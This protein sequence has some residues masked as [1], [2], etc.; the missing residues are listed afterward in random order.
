LESGT[1]VYAIKLDGFQVAALKD[2]LL[3]R[4]T[5]LAH[6]LFRRVDRSWRFRGVATEITVPLLS[7]KELRLALKLGCSTR[8]PGV[9]NY[10]YLA[11]YCHEDYPGQ[12]VRLRSVEKPAKKRTFRIAGAGRKKFTRTKLYRITSRRQRSSKQ[13]STTN[14]AKAKSKTKKKQ[15]TRDADEDDVEEL[16][17]LEE[18][19]ELEEA[20]VEEPDTDDDE[21]DEEEPAPKK[22]AKKA[23]AGKKGGKATAKKRK[24]AEEDEDDEDSDDEEDEDEKPAKKKAAKKGAKKGGKKSAKKRK[25]EEDEDEDEDEEEEAPKKSKKSAKS[26]KAKGG[27]SAGKSTKELTGGV[28]TAELAEAASEI[29]EVEIEGRDVRVW[30]R[31]NEIEKD[32]ESGRYTWPSAN[33]KEFKKLAKAIA[34]EFEDE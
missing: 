20:D 32:E 14:M 26:K 30:L 22:K 12:E 21:D 17:G 3:E 33:N 6:R 34:K 5:E 7:K 29:A 4:D 23:K 13:E 31:K 25:V 24:A 11:I 28:G 15:N 10:R 19:E 16:E 18:L 8:S 1:L 2:R 27:G 9:V